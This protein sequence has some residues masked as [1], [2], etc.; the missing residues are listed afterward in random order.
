MTDLRPLLDI[1]CAALDQTSGLVTEMAPGAVQA[2]GDRDMVSEIDFAVEERVREFLQKET[3]EIGFLG[4]EHGAT[5]LGG[6]LTW[7]LDPVDGTAN[8][9]N[10]IPL[11][12]VSLGLIENDR[13]VLGVIDLPFLGQR[14]KAAEGHG[15]YADGSR[16]A[17]SRTKVLSEAIVGVGDYAV[18]EHAQERNVRR[19]ALTARLAESVLRVRMLGSAALDLVWVASGKLDASIALSNHPWDMAAGVAIAR[20][21]GAVVMDIDGTA[22]DLRSAATIAV[23]PGLR[24]PVMGLLT[25]L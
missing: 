2:K 8:L 24:D 10:G 19:L 1:A 6:S 9:V 4:E 16:I 12:G 3:P 22:H 15:A 13:A 20:E 25:V 23:T 21:A 18:G 5:G 11:C 14:F 17:V 7:A